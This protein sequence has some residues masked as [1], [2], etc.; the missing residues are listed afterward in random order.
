VQDAHPLRLV[1]RLSAVDGGVHAETIMSE[2]S[3][4]EKL[5]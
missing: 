5:A 4:E 2:L 3:S 1:R